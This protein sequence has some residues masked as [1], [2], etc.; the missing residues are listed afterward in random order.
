[1]KHIIKKNFDYFFKIFI[2]Y[3]FFLTEFFYIFSLGFFKN[4]N[5]NNKKDY[6]QLYD[7]LKIN[8]K[9]SLPYEIDCKFIIDHNF[10]L[11]LALLTQITIKSS[12]INIDHGKILY[13]VLR[14]YIESNKIK[15]INIFEVGTAKGFS[16]LCMAKALHD[17]QIEGNIFSFD[18]LDHKKKRHWNSITD[19][20]NPNGIS[21]NDLL[22]KWDYLI[23]KYCIFV[24]GFS[25]LN[26]DKIYVKRINF[27]FLDGSHYGHDI[28][29][30]FS[31]IAKYQQRGDIV[32]FDDYNKIKYPDLVKSIDDILFEFNYNKLMVTGDDGRNYVISKKI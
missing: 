25:H 22:K 16:A 14:N 3:F 9:N 32:L 5:S 2:K 8:Y 18:V 19:L 26:L 20:E 11:E 24:S 7:Q 30:E 29:F 13:S 10:I 12:K 23:E 28:K 1:M 15:K 4:K 17:H 31:K 21:R 6:L 27:A